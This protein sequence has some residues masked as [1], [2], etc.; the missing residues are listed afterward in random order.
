MQESRDGSNRISRLSSSQAQE[1]L[2]QIK[3]QPY[4]DYRH[5]WDYYGK[6][7]IC[8]EKPL[9][10]NVELTAACNLRCCMCY[11]NYDMEVR[12]GALALSDVELL[13]KQFAELGIPSLWL[14]GGEPLIH[15]EIDQILKIFGQ[16]KPLDFWMVTNGLML[17]ES[18]S[19][20]I[21]EAGL[22]WL[23][24]SV[25]AAKAETYKKIRGGNYQK[26]LE[27]INTFLKVRSEK[28]SC[29]PFLR[30]SFI[31]MEQNAGE[32]SEFVAQWKDKADIIDFQTLADYHDLEQFTEE[33]VKNSD[34]ICTA[35]FSLVS[36]IPNGD[37]IPCCNG[38]YGEK[39]LYNIHNTKITDYWAS[40][41]HTAFALSIK[42]R[43][44]C[45][46]CIKC[47]KSFLPRNNR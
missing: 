6:N 16:T 15:P 13:A 35:P 18:L 5:A 12:N 45:E 34:Y 43:E 26:L 41:F 42:R 32:E 22:T 9:Q 36:V 33:D 10:L 27:N 2:R 30:V 31:K 17:T 4:D 14:S 44:Y 46:E 21:V 8:P 7:Q 24:V 38:F 37:I 23:S 19:S 25:D 3:G 40:D 29:L 1:Y 28:G 39:S 47:V 20:T 11:R